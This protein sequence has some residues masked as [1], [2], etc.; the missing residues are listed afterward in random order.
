[1]AD[2]TLVTLSVGPATYDAE[3]EAGKAAFGGIATDMSDIALAA[4]SS[5]TPVASASTRAIPAWLSLLPALLA[6]LMALAFRQVIPALFLGIWIGASLAHGIAFPSVW[7]G[8]LDATASYMLDALQDPGH[9]SVIMFTIMIGGMVGII[10][11]NGGTAGIVANIVGWASSPKRGQLTTAVLGVTI[12]FDDYANTLIV[13]NTMRPVTDRLK[14]SREKL[15]YIVDSTA[16]PIATIALATTWIG[17]EVGLIATAVAGIDGLDQSAYLIF[18]NSIAYSFYPILAIL[19]VFLIASIGRDF[20]PMLTSEQRARTSGALSRSDAHVGESADEARERAARTDRPMRAVNAV[21]PV[22]ILVCGTF[23]GIYLTGSAGS[24]PDASLHDI[25]GNGDPFVAMIWAS[26]SA[27]VVAAAMT[28]AQRIL[29]LAEIVDAWFAGARSMLLAIIILTLAWSL[30]GV[31]DVLHTGDFLVSLLG[32]T[33]APGLI[34]A[35]VFVLSAFTA[36]A[37]GSSWG[38]MGIMMPL[39]V[40]LTWAVM[41]AGALTSS[42]EH[43]HILYSAVAAVMAGAV[44]GDHCSPISDTTILSSL[45]SGCDHI[46]H[47]RTQLPYAALV[48]V[49]A[50]LVAILPAGFG[51]PWWVVLPLGAAMLFVAL[52]L[53]GRYTEDAPLHP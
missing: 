4:S 5:G 40:P 22:L 9:L 8:F 43:F 27:V 52:R 30:S 48:G 25:I 49:V 32:E 34:P 35:L 39:V 17:F 2:G 23:A 36:F 12:F 13:G 7:Y 47:V 3:V 21:I 18:L 37:T 24:A 14:V 46:D 45:A 26:S 28:L 19:F 38:V 6:I 10:S 51:V 33:L 20:G 53:L 42:T 1:L 31:N 50:L 29:N 16:A 15:A 11:R 44:W 41:D